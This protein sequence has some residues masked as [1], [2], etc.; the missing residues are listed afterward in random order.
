MK[1]VGMVVFFF[2][3]SIWNRLE[4][5]YLLRHDGTAD[6]RKTGSCHHHHR[7]RF[8]RLARSDLEQK[9]PVRVKRGDMPEPSAHQVIGPSPIAG[10]LRACGMNV[11]H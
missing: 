6:C 11:I 3:N 1:Q 9:Q 10:A 4:I 7:G 8:D 5:I 2:R